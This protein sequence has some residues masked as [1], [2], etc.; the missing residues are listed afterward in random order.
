MGFS[1]AELEQLVIAAFFLSFNA[2]K[3]DLATEDLVQAAQE[4]VPLSDTMREGIAELRLWAETRARP[5][6]SVQ[7]EPTIE[8]NRTMPGMQSSSNGYRNVTTTETTEETAMNDEIERRLRG[9]EAKTAT[10]LSGVMGESQNR[11]NLPPMPLNEVPHV[12]PIPPAPK[13]PTDAEENS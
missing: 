2:D 4:T 11:P 3:R 1:G 7:S 10:G 5:T 6:S 9:L 12:V 13:E 8:R